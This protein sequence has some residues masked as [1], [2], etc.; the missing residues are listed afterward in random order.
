MLTN[1]PLFLPHPVPFLCA[2]SFTFTF[3][4]YSFLKKNLESAYERIYLVLFQPL[5]SCTRKYYTVWQNTSKKPLG[6]VK[7]L[8]LK[9]PCTL[10]IGPRRFELA[11]TSKHFLWRLAFMVPRAANQA[12]KHGEQGTILPNYDAREGLA[13]PFNSKGAAVA[14][15]PWS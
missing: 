13:W 14:W 2:N 9:T 7:S 6:K 12:S 11:L 1:Y 8:L 10:D 5:N 4:F 15:T 3:M